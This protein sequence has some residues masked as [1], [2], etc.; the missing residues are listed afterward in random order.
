M[1]AVERTIDRTARPGPALSGRALLA[2]VL[3][4]LALLALALLALGACGPT[5]ERL[6]L[7][8]PTDRPNVVLIVTDD[9]GW[10]E[11]SCYGNEVY[12]TPNIDR[13]AEEG[14]SFTQFYAN[15][16][17]CVPTRF[18]LLS[19]RYPNRDG[20]HGNSGLFKNEAADEAMAHNLPRLLGDA[21]YVTGLVGKWHLGFVR[22]LLPNDRSFD[23]F[24]GFLSGNL[25]YTNLR[26]WSGKKDWWENTELAPEDGYLTHLITSN[27]VKFVERHRDEPFF[28]FLS[29]AAPHTPYQA[30]GDAP[31]RSREDGHIEVEEMRKD[32]PVAYEQMVTE[33]DDGIG[34]V[35]DTI[36]RL[37][38]GPNT[39]VVFVSDNG[40]R[41]YGQTGPFS[42]WK[43]SV[44][45]GGVRVPCIVR[46]PGQIA[47]GARS[48]QVAITHDLLPTFVGAAGGEF[49]ADWTYDG[50]DLMPTLRGEGALTP[51]TLHWLYRTTREEIR[52]GMRQDDWK[53]VFGMNRPLLFE[54]DSD[55]GELRDVAAEHPE[56]V[57]AMV[58]ELSTWAR[59][60]AAMDDFWMQTQS[61]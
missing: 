45:E 56:R 6:P 54:L 36:D 32:V 35:L 4:S 39:L 24:R 53:L 1:I 52:A 17:V 40:P 44:W 43:T 50:I 9:M 19:G 58:S 12:D 28:L 22:G 46:W 23:W 42:G 7:R 60:V 38:L 34:E 27:A 11:P 8:A 14:L 13:L 48:E 47:A 15:S 18:S 49:P 41:K 33:M 55:P 51:R 30:P 21:G 37:G 10:A 2:P 59:D 61:L 3:L 5:E 20:I 25:D 57:R 16:P 29:H 31:V 26:N